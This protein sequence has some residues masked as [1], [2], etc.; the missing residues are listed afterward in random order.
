MRKYL[1]WIEDGLAPLYLDEVLLLLAY[2]YIVPLV[3][4]YLISGY[5][6]FAHIQRNN[7]T[8]LGSLYLPDLS[9]CP[10][11]CTEE[12]YPRTRYD[13]LEN[14]WAAALGEW[15]KDARWKKLHKSTSCVNTIIK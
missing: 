11:T 9:D 14:D 12:D 10:V 1:R 15:A 7:T 8:A 3:G 4:A 2:P 6:L 5:K 13:V